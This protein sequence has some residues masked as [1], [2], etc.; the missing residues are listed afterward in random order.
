MADAKQLTYFTDPR[1]MLLSSLEPEDVLE[2][3]LSLCP[4][5]KGAALSTDC[6]LSWAVGDRGANWRPFD[7]DQGKA[8]LR[9]YGRPEGN[10]PD[11]LLDIAATALSH[12]I[13]LAKAEQMAQVDPLTG[14]FNRRVFN[15]TTN[16]D[17]GAL[18]V[19]DLDNFKTIN[20]THGHS[21]GD[22]I[23]THAGQRLLMTLRS[24]DRAFRLGG[25]E[26]AVWV[27]MGS[28]DSH[29]ELAERIRQSLCFEYDGVEVTASAGYVTGRGPAH[30][31]LEAAD[32]AL[33]EA[34][35]AGR[36]QIRFNDV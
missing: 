23:L 31:H 26:F 15:A 8:S 29:A 34:K 32:R 10:V 36:N 5:F 28:L 14:L 18:I 17:H 33:Y 13:R 19:L 12:C 1:V 3:L 6:G 22:R 7:L 30:S 24:G 27:A 25:E 35:A 4:D 9:L 16:D 2:R 11:A 20:D 21:M